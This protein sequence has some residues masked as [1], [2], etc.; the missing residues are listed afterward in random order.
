MDKQTLSRRQHGREDA[1]RGIVLRDQTGAVLGRGRT[2][3]VS[4]SGMFAVVDIQS[5]PELNTEVLLDI[6]LPGSVVS[7]GRTGSQHAHYVA[8]V[9]RT[10]DVD[11]LIGVGLKLVEQIG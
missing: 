3:N 4:D 11:G 7:D 1:Q 10:E 8:R 6:C 2:L 5:A 9:V